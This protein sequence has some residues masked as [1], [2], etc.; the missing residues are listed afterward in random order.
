MAFPEIHDTIIVHVSY[1][2]LPG[3]NLAAPMIYT[4]EFIGYRFTTY[5]THFTDTNKQLGKPNANMDVNT[6]AP[7]PARSS[8]CRAGRLGCDS[9]GG[10]TIISTTYVS[11]NHLKQT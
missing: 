8:A 2:W 1:N 9:W 6:G 7:S 5:L 10:L 11:E 4:Y 3:A